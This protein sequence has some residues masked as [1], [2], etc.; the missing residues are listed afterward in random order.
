MGWK[1][2][3]V[4]EAHG[5]PRKLLEGCTSKGEQWNV[6]SNSQPFGTFL[7]YLKFKITNGLL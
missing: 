3:V 7:L 5:D 1:V 6:T 2:Q 4:T